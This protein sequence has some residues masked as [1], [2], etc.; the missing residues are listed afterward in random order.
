MN[1]HIS[2]TPRVDALYAAAEGKGS[3]WEFTSLDNL[4]RELERELAATLAAAAPAPEPQVPLGCD[5]CKATHLAHCS[6]PIHCG[7]M[8]WGYTTL[9]DLS[10]KLPCGHHQSLGATTVESG[11][12]LCELCDARQRRDDAE[13]MEADLSARVRELEGLLREVVEGYRWM[14][15][16]GYQTRLL[17]RIRAALEEK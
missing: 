7:G 8:K 13:K 14:R 4:A 16:N 6:D 5:A 10:A 17:E 2:D 11:V 9:P 3:H 1:S 12:T 15:D